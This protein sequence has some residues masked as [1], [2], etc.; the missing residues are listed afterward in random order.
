MHGE[1]EVSLKG[2]VP[3]A[4]RW[5][6]KSYAV[7]EILEVWRDTGRWWEEEAPKL[8]FRLRTAGGGLWEIYRDEARGTWHLYKVYD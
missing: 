1:L 7:L 3:R 6:G 4:F 8:F 5:R 2:D